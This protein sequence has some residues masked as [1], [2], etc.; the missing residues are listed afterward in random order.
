M[1][2]AEDIV[3]IKNKE[4]IIVPYKSGDSKAGL[5]FK[6]IKKGSEIP[7]DILVRMVARNIEKVA[8]VK[9]LDKIPINLPKGLYS[10]PEPEK[11]VIKRRKYSQDSLTGIYDEKGFSALK[12]IGEEFGVTDRSSRRLIVEILRAQEEQRA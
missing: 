11:M 6:V 8:D 9:Y 7:Y 5:T 10:K 3:I 1:K 12:K 4:G 2:A